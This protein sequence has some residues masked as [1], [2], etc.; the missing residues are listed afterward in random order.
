MS[1]IGPKTQ[2]LSAVRARRVVWAN[3]GVDVD[4]RYGFEPVGS[5]RKLIGEMQ[6]PGWIR[7]GDEQTRC[8]G[9]RDQDYNL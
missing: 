8:I 6:H 2:P 9:W 1:A 7:I 4:E 3:D 5:D